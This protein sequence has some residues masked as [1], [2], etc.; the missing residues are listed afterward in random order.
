MCRGLVDDGFDCDCSAQHND[1][2]Y[3][4]GLIKAYGF[5]SLTP[6]SSAMTK[7][8]KSNARW[9]NQP[10]L[11]SSILSPHFASYP[12]SRTFRRKFWKEI[13]GHL[14]STI[15]HSDGVGEEEKVDERIY[16][17][18]VELLGEEGGGFGNGFVPLP[19]LI[20]IGLTERNE[21]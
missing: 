19:K 9:I 1:D 2:D 12:P 4:Y 3:T 20:S 6:S 18:Y 8:P 5:G 17:I 10:L 11:L 14:E 21:R 15:L 13:I 16:E 7:E